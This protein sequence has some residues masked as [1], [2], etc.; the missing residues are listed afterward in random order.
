[1]DEDKTSAG[2]EGAIGSASG[3]V[4]PVVGECTQLSCRHLLGLIVEFGRLNDFVAARKLGV[5]LEQVREWAG[6][7]EEEGWIIK[8]ELEVGIQSYS[9]TKDGSDRLKELRAEIKFRE[10]PVD[11]KPKSKPKNPLVLLFLTPLRLTG[12][13]YLLKFIK[14]YPRDFLLLATTLFSVY[15]LYLFIQEPNAEALS[16][17]FAVLMFSVTLLLYNH[18]KKH[19]KAGGLLG[20]ADW[21]FWVVKSRRKYFALIAIYVLLIYVVAK[22]ILRPLD[23]APYLMYFILLV[24]TSVLLYYPKKTLFGTIKF[25]VGMAALMYSVILIAGLSS[26]TYL[27]AGTAYRLLDL[28]VGFCVI[29]LVQLNEDTLGV[30]VKSLRRML[31]E[32]QAKN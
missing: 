13:L 28:F 19:S 2:D 31:K 5:S 25:Y 26:L 15:L 3:S 11:D 23:S 32:Q 1:M 14:S 9:V 17:F 6:E 29:T 18:Y 7:L 4:A 12:I 8:S 30:G 10:T 22:I 24:S 21:L 16:F 27:L 20:F